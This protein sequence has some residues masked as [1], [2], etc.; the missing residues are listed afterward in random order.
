MSNA[1]IRVKLGPLFLLL[2]VLL[3]AMAGLILLDKPADVSN[4]P[5][6]GGSFH[7]LNTDGRAVTQDDYLGQ[8]A[9]LFFGYTHCPDI[10]PTTLF[11]ISELFRKFNLSGKTRAIFVTVD[12]ERDSPAMMKDYLSSFATEIIGLSG[13]RAAIDDVLRKYRVYAKKFPGEGDDYNMDHSAIIY[14]MDRSM[15]FVRP[16]ALDDPAKAAREIESLM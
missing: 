9:L 7:L 2:G 11:E 3:S 5:S 8:P 1:S 4:G 6:I 13:D 16:I 14:L 12:P 10:C 15:R